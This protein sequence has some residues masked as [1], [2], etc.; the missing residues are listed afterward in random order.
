VSRA[1]AMDHTKLVQRPDVHG[2]RLPR[3]AACRRVSLGQK[4]LAG[5]RP[6]GGYPLGSNAPPGAL[7]RGVG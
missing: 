7:R 6:N 3:G 2:P 5:G 4:V 1:G